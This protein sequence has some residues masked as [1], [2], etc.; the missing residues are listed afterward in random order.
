MVLLFVVCGWREEA[1]AGVYRRTYSVHS[2]Y[3]Y[4]CTS[5][6]ISLFR[7]TVLSRVST[8]QKL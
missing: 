5:A 4:V 6:T 1:V 7:P 2:T 3:N 8:S